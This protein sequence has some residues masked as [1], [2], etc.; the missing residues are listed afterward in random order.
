[1][2]I[3]NG[4]E[5]VITLPEGKEVVILRPFALLTR[6]VHRKIEAP[7]VATIG[8]EARQKTDAQEELLV[9]AR[10]GHR[11]CEGVRTIGVTTVER[12]TLGPS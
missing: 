10:H 3:T 2:K 9:P 1:M 5:N 11:Y 7:M 12:D 4:A 8:T 6:K